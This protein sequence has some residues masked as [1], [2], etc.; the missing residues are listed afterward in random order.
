M[1]EGAASDFQL[2]KLVSGQFI[3]RL[4]LNRFDLFA[5]WLVHVDSPL[6]SGTKTVVEILTFFMFTVFHTFGAAI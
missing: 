3:L 2:Q 5:D 4:D 1:V 6:S